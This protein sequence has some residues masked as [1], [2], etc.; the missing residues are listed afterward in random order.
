MRQENNL[1]D[2]NIVVVRMSELYDMLLD[3]NDSS[4]PLSIDSNA[5]Y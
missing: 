5:V 4:M 3:V 1:S 2:D